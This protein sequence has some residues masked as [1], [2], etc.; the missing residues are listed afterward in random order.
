MRKILL[1][2]KNGQLGWEL[3][4][5]LAPL[6]EVRVWDRS[7]A[8]LEDIEAL[9]RAVRAAGAHVIVN[10]A[11]YTAVDRAESEPQR[12]MQINAL[13]PR[14]LAQVARESGALLVHYSSDYVFNGSGNA[15][16][17]ETCAPAPLSAYGRSKLAGEQHIQASGCRHVIF[18]TSWVYGARGHNFIRTMLRLA[19]ERDMLRVVGDQWGAPTGAELIADITAHAIA[20]NLAG[21]YHLSSAGCTNWHA[22]TEYLIACARQIAPQRPWKVRS[23]QAITTSEYP[24]AAQRPHNSRLDTSRLRQHLDIHL[25]DWQSGVQ[26]VLREMLAF[27][28]GN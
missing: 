28:A 13:A 27:E 25:P 4:R 26:R 1:L 19:Q 20:R 7:A 11:A 14:A 10:A 18:R 9:A 21:L 6:G 3:Q 22:L 15:P 23:V 16:H 17:A 8:N 5:S 24:T 2:G 12:A